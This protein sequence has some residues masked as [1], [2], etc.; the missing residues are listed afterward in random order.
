MGRGRVTPRT[1]RAVL[2]AAAMALS[3]C[4]SGSSPQ[5]AT[6]P[7]TTP[8]PVQVVVASGTASIPARR[9]LLVPFTLPSTGTLDITVD[10][11][12]PA[13]EIDIYLAVG[14]CTVE[15]WPDCNWIDG[16]ESRDFKPERL[17]V[18]AGQPG[19]YVLDIGNVGPGAESVSFEVTL[20]TSGLRGQ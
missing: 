9:A 5:Q 7:T 8:G 14:S 3:A 19:P 1:P 6:P 4:G 16:S 13:N 18:L 11:T 12:F 2:A 10:W 20:T 17:R 15:Q